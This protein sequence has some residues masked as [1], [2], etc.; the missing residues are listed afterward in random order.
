MFWGYAIIWTALLLVPDPARIFFL[1][2]GASEPFAHSWVPVNEIAHVS[3]YFLLM[4]L[5][6]AAFHSKSPGIGIAWLLAGGAAHAALTELAQL[7]V[8]PRVCDWGDFLLDVVG[9]AV[10]ALIWWLFR[11]SAPSRNVAEQEGHP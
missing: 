1:P 8:P 10:G 9:L 11:R 2:A 5:A 7:A 3:G 6:A 4:L